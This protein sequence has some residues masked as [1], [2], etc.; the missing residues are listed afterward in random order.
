MFVDASALVA[1]VAAEPDGQR[2]KDKLKAAKSSATSAIAI[3]E[4]TQALARLRSIDVDTAKVVVLDLIEILD[5]TIADLTLEIALAA[6]DASRRYGKGRH[7]ARLNMGDCFAYAC[8]QV[9]D[10]PLLFKGD[11]FSRTDIKPA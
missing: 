7:P 3:W 8:A 11:D 9:L 5:I 4:A 2:Y 6:I 1:V 10:V